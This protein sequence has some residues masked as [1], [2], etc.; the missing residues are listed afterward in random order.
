MWETIMS[1]LERI[2]RYLVELVAPRRRTV[3][4]GYDWPQFSQ[5][6]QELTMYIYELAYKLQAL[7]LRIRHTA[8]P[9]PPNWRF[10][11]RGWAGTERMRRDNP[12]W[13]AQQRLLDEHLTR[14]VNLAVPGN[15]EW[16]QERYPDYIARRLRQ[17]QRDMEAAFRESLQ[18][19]P[20]PG[21]WGLPQW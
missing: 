9:T 17:Q 15:V 21:I 7:T 11:R 8:Y 16:L 1:Y 3:R 6:P 18:P 13:L 10:V 4:T 5:L 19:S 20:G 14:R 2:V 12:W